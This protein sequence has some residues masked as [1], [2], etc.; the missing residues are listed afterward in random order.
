M[1]LSVGPRSGPSHLVVGDAGGS[2]WAAAAWSSSAASK[3]LRVAVKATSNACPGSPP[4]PESTDCAVSVSRSA[5]AA[6][7]AAAGCGAVRAGMPD[8]A[9]VRTPSGCAAGDSAAPSGSDTSAGWAG[10]AT[11][12]V[13]TAGAMSAGVAIPCGVSSSRPT[14]S[15]A[16]WFRAPGFCEIFARDVPALSAD[17]PS[18]VSDWMVPFSAGAKRAVAASWIGLGAA[19]AASIAGDRMEKPAA[20]PAG[21]D[22]ILAPATTGCACGVSSAQNMAP[23][24]LWALSVTGGDPSRNRVRGMPLAAGA[25]AAVLSAG[26]VAAPGNLAGAA[27]DSVTARYHSRRAGVGVMP[28]AGAADAAVLTAGGAAL[29][30]NAVGAGA[31]S[32]AAGDHSLRSGLWGMPL[33]AGAGAAVL[34]AGAVAPARNAAWAGADSGAA[35]DHSL[36]GGL[37]GMPLVAGAGAAV[38]AAGA[39]APARNAAWAGA[40]SGAAGDHS[41][42]GG[43]WGMPLVA[44]AGAAV[45][46]AGGVAPARNAAGAGSEVARGPS[47]GRVLGGLA[48]LCGVTGCAVLPPGLTSADDVQCVMP[49]AVS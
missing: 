40:D 45:F 19:G 25:G 30:R 21:G 42:R 4:S 44:G 11:L 13:T 9:G 15:A 47:P 43:L 29:V 34:A 36:R 39:V 17:C 31:G 26:S 37:W 3:G 28:L 14:G 35:G 16:H 46:A 20:F 7:A 10:G 27:A 33:V 8:S 23:G 32:G 41:L 22:A 18:G 49:A 1:G 5:E 12:P 48:V 38:L 24:S 2:I 6:V